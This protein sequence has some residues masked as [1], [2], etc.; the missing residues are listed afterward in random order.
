[1]SRKHSRNSPELAEIAKD[2]QQLAAGVDDDLASDLLWGV[3]GKN[4]IAAFL[5][6]T[7]RQVYYLI[8]RKI[9]PVK[10]HGHRT[11]TGRKSELRRHFTSRAG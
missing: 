10:K 9:L 2:L 11:I 5:N 6:L 4:G 3:D 7:P 1:M 8:E